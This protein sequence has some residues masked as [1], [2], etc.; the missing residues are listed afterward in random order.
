MKVIVIIYSGDLG[1]PTI[2]HHAI[3]PYMADPKMMKV[4]DE[5][6]HGA[7]RAD[8]KNGKEFLSRMV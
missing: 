6:A 7:S 3:A 8:L 2:V 4:E 5:N 1:K